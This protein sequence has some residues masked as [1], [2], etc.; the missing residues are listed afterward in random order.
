MVKYGLVAATLL[1]L[2]GCLG[3]PDTGAPS[4][5]LSHASRKEEGNNDRRERCEST[6]VGGE[7][8]TVCY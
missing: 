5:G 1:L 7:P 6:S 3:D 4:A 8:K 2:G